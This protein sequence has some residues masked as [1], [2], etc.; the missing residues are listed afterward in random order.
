MTMMW[1]I[2]STM[3]SS[4]GTMR[5]DSSLPSG[6]FQP[7]ALLGHLVDAVEFQ[8]EQ[9]AD[10]QPAGALQQQ[11]ASGQ[12][13]AGAGPLQFLG[14]PPVGVDGQVAGQDHG[15]LGDV[16]AEHQP[17]RW[18]L[19]PSPFGDV[20][21]E[22]G[23]SEDP[24]AAFSDGDDLAGLGVDDVD[25]RRQVWLDVPA[26]LQFGDAGQRRVGGGEEHPECISRLA[27]EETVFGTHVARLRSR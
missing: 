25:L 20:G 6:D 15:E 5:S 11:C 7:R 8:V 4:S 10:A 12:F 17:A 14:Q 24:A 19:R 3:S 2:S 21:E 9:F 1:S 23:Q 16:V 18:C 13:V 22:S 27:R 26:P